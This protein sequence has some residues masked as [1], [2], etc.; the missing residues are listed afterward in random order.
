MFKKG[1]CEWG[2][3][4]KPLV[5]EDDIIDDDCFEFLVVPLFVAVISYNSYEPAYTITIIK[6]GEVSEEIKYCYGHS[7]APREHF[8]RGSYLKPQRSTNI[9]R[10]MFSLVPGMS[11]VIQTKYLKSLLTYR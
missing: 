3:L 7:I 8:L 2:K 11:S 1:T 9:S 5:T 4:A 6:K 10:K